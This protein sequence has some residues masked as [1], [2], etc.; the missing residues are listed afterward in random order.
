MMDQIRKDAELEQ[1]RKERMKYSEEIKKIEEKQKIKKNKQ[2]EY[3]RRYGNIFLKSNPLF[4]H[5]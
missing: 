3:M 5:M 2:A 4:L 1:L